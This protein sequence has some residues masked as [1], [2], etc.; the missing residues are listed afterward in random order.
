MVFCFA[1]KHLIRKWKRIIAH[2]TQFI[3]KNDSRL[4]FTNREAFVLLSTNPMTIDHCIESQYAQRFNY[5][6]KTFRN[7]V[8]NKQRSS[9]FIMTKMY[10]QRVYLFEDSIR[11]TANKI[12]LFHSANRI[13][14]KLA[15]F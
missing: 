8:K 13:R 5:E 9:S 11:H 4:E 10:S 15:H 14:N 6:F 12:K 7:V 2:S 3:I 1:C